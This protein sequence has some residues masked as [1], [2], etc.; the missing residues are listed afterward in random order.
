[1][2]V[3]ERIKKIRGEKSQEEFSAEV[4]VHKNT[5]SRWERGERTPD[6]NDLI[7][8]LEIHP[9]INPAWLLTGENP[10]RRTD[11]EG[12]AHQTSGTDLDV[13]R[14]TL[15]IET[16]EEA[17]QATGRSMRANKKAQIVTAVYDFFKDEDKEEAKDKV[18]RL[19]KTAI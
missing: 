9:E 17:L 15:A 12:R 10:M 19:I 16:I 13:D 5:L 3:S 11:A 4:G 1:M 7:R 6:H 8:L 14:L 2:G 18:L